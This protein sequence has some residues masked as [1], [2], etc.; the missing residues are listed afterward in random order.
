MS[1]LNR[2]IMLDKGEIMNKWHLIR[3]IKIPDINAVENDIADEN[4]VTWKKDTEGII[5]ISFSKNENGKNFCYDDLMIIGYGEYGGREL[6]P[7]YIKGTNQQMINMYR[8]S[9][10]N[11]NFNYIEIQTNRIDRN[12]FSPI[13]V[14]QKQYIAEPIIC[15]GNASAKGGHIVDVMFD[16]INITFNP[17]KSGELKFYGRNVL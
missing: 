6:A 14:Y 1:L 16:S 9:P 13:A 15:I 12:L 5:S 4:G 10:F 7:L 2:R 11:A 8:C 17:M 3:T